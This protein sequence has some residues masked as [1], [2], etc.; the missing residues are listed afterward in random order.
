MCLTLPI[1]KA[2]IICVYSRTL[3]VKILVIQNTILTQYLK[4]D[5]IT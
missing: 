4:K 1:S 5:D 2:V 3:T